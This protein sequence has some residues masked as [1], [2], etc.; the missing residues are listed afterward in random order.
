VTLAD[1]RGPVDL[2]QRGRRLI[3]GAALFCISQTAY[4]QASQTAQTARAT[5]AAANPVVAVGEGRSFPAALSSAM[6]MAVESGAGATVVGA[7]S[8]KGDRITTDSTRA[9]SRGV[10]TRYVVLDSSNVAGGA[11]VRILAMVSPIAE[12]D[13]VGARAQR[14]AAPGGLWSANAALDAER[15]ASEGE[16]LSEFF[17]AI[18]RQPN[19]YAYEV[20]A[21]PPVPSGSNLRLRLRI[22]RS[23]ADAYAALRERAYAILS[24]VA[25]PAGSR[26]IHLPPQS[27]E[28]A[29]VKPCV[30]H[31]AAGERRVLNVRA[32]IE[33][34][35]S[36]GAFDPPVLTASGAAPVTTLFPDLRTAGGFVVAFVDAAKQRQQIVHV[37]STRGYLAAV[38]YLRTTFD[39]ARF[40]IEV[41]SRTI[42]IV[43]SFRAPKTGQPQP[44]FITTSPPGSLPIE[45]VRGFRPALAGGPGAPTM[46]GSPYI[47]LTVPSSDQARVDT[48]IVDV[49]LTSAELSQ[50]T[51]ISV[52]PIA[53]THR[54]VATGAQVPVPTAVPLAVLDAISRPPLADGD[55]AVSITSAQASV[56]AVGTGVVDAASPT[57]ACAIARLRAQRELIR[58]ISGSHLE[59]RIGLSTAESRGAPVQ[60]QFREEITESVAGHLAGA[61]L[62]AQW[63]VNAPARCR[64]ALWLADCLT[65]RRDSTAHLPR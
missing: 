36:L 62:A 12:R 50:M 23:P 14:I 24:A 5:P 34:T 53:T 2:M 27:T 7:V 11:H 42:D 35:D 63:T 19:A 26:T 48:A 43:E 29:D 58:Y 15:R 45:L 65:V 8:A 1:G 10:V 40:R 37:R 39:D 28:Q 3:C 44:R 59:G 56:V 54:L 21:G 46:L 60:E 22:I 17:G 49:T 32:A 38:D 31:C 55:G 25:G 47:I 13:A 20:E 52:E 9:V 51:D 57:Q 41:G 18:D 61:A 6:R 16:L 33:N 30:S 64:V 4:T